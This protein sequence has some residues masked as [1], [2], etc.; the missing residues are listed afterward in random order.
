VSSWLLFGAAFVWA[1]FVRD[2]DDLL[3]PAVTEK[4]FVLLKSY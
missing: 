4:L 3:A 2:D 1:R